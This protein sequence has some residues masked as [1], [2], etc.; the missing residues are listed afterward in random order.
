MWR[1]LHAEKSEEVEIFCK[2]NR[3]YLYDHGSTLRPNFSL[4]HGSNNEEEILKVVRGK[5][6]I[7]VHRKRAKKII[8]KLHRPNGQVSCMP[9]GAKRIEKTFNEVY[10]IND[11]RSLVHDV[12][13]N[14]DGTCKQMKVAGAPPPPKAVTTMM[15]MERIQIDLIEM[16][17]SRSPLHRSSNHNNRYIL[18]VI[19]C[20]SKYCW[21]MPLPTKEAEPIVDR[22]S[23]I[24]REFGCPH[25]L[26]SDNGKEFVATITG[27]L[28]SQLKIKKIHGRPYHPQSQGQIE[29]LNKRVKKAL[30]C[31]LLRF[32]SEEHSNVWPLLLNEVSQ[33]LNNTFSTSIQ[34]VPFRVFLGRDSGQFGLNNTSQ[35]IAIL[36]DDADCTESAHLDDLEF[37]DGDMKKDGKVIEDPAKISVSFSTTQTSFLAM[38]IILMFLNLNFL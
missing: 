14:C 32:P 16:Y 34:D 31:I 36:P 22:L 6:K 9:T 5:K 30:G 17:G 28:C 26:Q 7:V 33:L 3:K 27:E 4:G 18:S 35:P 21:L 11:T 12:L 23:T 8:A 25:I 19:D 2:V 29:S 10:F 38:C 20:F 13:T 15:V 1:F 24:F 37:T